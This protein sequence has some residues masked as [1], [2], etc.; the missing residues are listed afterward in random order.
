MQ[1]TKLEEQRKVIGED[2]KKYVESVLKE[3]KIYKDQLILY[4]KSVSGVMSTQMRKIIIDSLSNFHKFIISCY[5]M[6][7]KKSATF[8]PVTPVSNIPLV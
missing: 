8:D 6:A 3:N 1:K 4:F 7:T 2:W 5:P